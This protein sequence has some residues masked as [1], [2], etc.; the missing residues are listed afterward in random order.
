MWPREWPS[1]ASST[2]RRRPRPRLLSFV[3]CSGV[4]K[5]STRDASRAARPARRDTRRPG[6]E[7][8]FRLP[9][10]DAEH[11]LLGLRQQRVSQASPAG[12]VRRRNDSTQARWVRSCPIWACRSSPTMR[13]NRDAV[14]RPDVLAGHD[15]APAAPKSRPSSDGRSRR[16]TDDAFAVALL[17]SVKY[18]RD[19]EGIG[20][21]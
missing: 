21:G 6:V 3:P 2:A 17:L 18:N 14:L 4:A 15:G 20:D 1:V 5:T 16:G 9:E 10:Q 13:P 12:T 11:P 8:P 19:H 7:A